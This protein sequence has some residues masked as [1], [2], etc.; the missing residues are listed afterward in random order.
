MTV[1]PTAHEAALPSRP[2]P[3]PQGALTVTPLE[4]AAETP[5]LLSVIVPT[6]NEALNIGRLVTQ[7]SQLLG[8][9]NVHPAQAPSA[10]RQETPHWPT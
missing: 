6:F 2:L 5:L 9:N 4:P 1:R 8:E 10:N 3:V 7:L